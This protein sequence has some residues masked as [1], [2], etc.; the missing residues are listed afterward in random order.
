MKLSIVGVFVFFVFSC[1]QQESKKANTPTYFDVAG[2]FEKEAARLQKKNPTVIKNV[3][4]KGDVEKKPIKIASW[5]TEFA[6][7]SNSDINK[8][9]WRGEFAEKVK[10]DSLSYTTNNPNIPIKKIEIIKFNDQI[11]SIKIFKSTKNSL[12]TSTDTLLY[13]PDSL[14]AIRSQQKIKLL[15]TKNYQ[16]IGSLK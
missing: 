9:S 7:F 4:A 15:S 16:V 1:S 5:K 8:A 13:Y 10:D 12:Y 2:Y 14:Y 11:K 3:L 6:S